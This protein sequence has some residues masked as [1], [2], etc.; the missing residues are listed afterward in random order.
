MHRDCK[1]DPVFY[2]WLVPKAPFTQDAEHLATR[3]R[4]LWNTSSS[5]GVF[6]QRVCR[7][8]CMQICLRVLCE[9]GPRGQTRPRKQ[10]ALP[11]DQFGLSAG[12]WVRE[13]DLK[14][15]TGVAN[16]S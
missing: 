8:I 11:W 3:A 4:K 5:M 2:H 15:E 9:W 1:H 14:I 6:T 16:E 13:S 7:Q 12:I 10:K